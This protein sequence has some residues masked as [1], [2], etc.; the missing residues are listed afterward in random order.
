MA[1][2]FISAILWAA[3]E[4]SIAVLLP[5]ATTIEINNFIGYRGLSNFLLLWP[6]LLLAFALNPNFFEFLGQLTTAGVIGLFSMMLI[7][8][9]TSLMIALGITYTSPIFIRI[10]ATLSTPASILFQRYEKE[11]VGG[12][13][14]AGCLL[15]IIGF[16]FINLKWKSKRFS[17][18]TKGSC[19]CKFLKAEPMNS[20]NNFR[21]SIT[22]SSLNQ[23]TTKLSAN[24]H[25]SASFSS[26]IN[27]L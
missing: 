26:I 8:V 4:V 18:K 25:F 6:L 14:Y 7:S 16:I 11:K 2:L 20:H 23:M 17:Y 12:Y 5:K 15:T 27:S 13:T 9:G 24:E 21:K 22:K 1:S 19:Q 10:G 3:Y